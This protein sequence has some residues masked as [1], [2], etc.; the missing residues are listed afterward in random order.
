MSSTIQ[1]FVVA[2]FL[3]GLGASLGA[4]T[5]EEGS[6]GSRRLVVPEPAGSKP[7]AVS[8]PRAATQA[9]AETPAEQ[10][11]ASVLLAPALATAATVGAPADGVVVTPSAVPVIVYITRT[12]SKYH[13]GTCR[14]LSESNIPMDF[15]EARRELEPCKG[16]KPPR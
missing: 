11:P 5:S 7:G 15:E 13:R 14:H 1:A 3:A 12:G 8:A 9:E 4:C 2:G 6:S 16:C 10:A